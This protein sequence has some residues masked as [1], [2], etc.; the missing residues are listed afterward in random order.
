MLDITDRFCILLKDK[1]PNPSVYNTNSVPPPVMTTLA[2]LPR[3]TRPVLLEIV[4]PWMI[5]LDT[6]TLPDASREYCGDEF[7]IPTRPLVTSRYTKFDSKA[8]SIPCRSRF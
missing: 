3:L 6:L 4:L 7:T 5:M 2:M 8:R 1:L